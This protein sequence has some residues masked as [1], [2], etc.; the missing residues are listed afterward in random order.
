MTNEAVVR[1]VGVTRGRGGVD[2]E[3]TLVTVAD[4]A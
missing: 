2:I 3:Q 1:E 4:K